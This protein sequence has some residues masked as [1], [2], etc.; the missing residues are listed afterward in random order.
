MS[1]MDVT[2]ESLSRDLNREVPEVYVIIA[3]HSVLGM[4]EEAIREIIGCDKAELAEV[5]NDEIYK[6]VRLV[7]G[8]MHAQAGVDQTTGWD[9]LEQLA[10]K[11]LVRRAELPNQDSEFLLKVAAVANKAQR[12]HTAGRDQGILDPAARPTRRI[13][14]TSRLVRSFN[15]DGT[16]TQTIE[17]QLS[18]H[19]GSMGHPTFDEVDQLL[20]VSQTPALPR[21][22]EVK[23]STP[24]VDFDDLN[25][26][27]KEKG[28]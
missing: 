19:D 28:F 18:I 13:N 15:R 9:K 1:L 4:D 20:H 23:T 25:E 12:R 11:N 6:Q 10:V 22:I 7:I 24:E 21:Q 2:H 8:A 5:L 3:K 26:A 17:K 16:E 27:M 14:L